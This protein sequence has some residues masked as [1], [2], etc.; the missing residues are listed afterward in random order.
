[1]IKNSENKMFEKWM[2]LFNHFIVIA[3]S[4][5][6]NSSSDNNSYKLYKLSKLFCRK[7]QRRFNID[8]DNFNQKSIL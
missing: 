3:I 4:E 1:M 8:I 7:L 2:N 5:N 6:K